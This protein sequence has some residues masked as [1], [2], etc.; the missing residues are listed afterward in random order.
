[1]PSFVPM[2]SQLSREVLRWQAARTQAAKDAIFAKI[3]PIAFARGVKIYKT[4]APKDIAADYDTAA[5]EIN[6]CIFKLAR[7]YKPKRDFE[8]ALW[9]KI[10]NHIID[11]QRTARRKKRR[12]AIADVSI[13]SVMGKLI[14]EPNPAQHLE[15]QDRFNEWKRATRGLSNVQ[16]HTLRRRFMFNDAYKKIAESLNRFFPRD[17]AWNHKHVE[18]ALLGAMKKMRRGG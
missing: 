17:R 4:V 13:E 2:R 7:V 15:E 9:V 10:C 6:L 8:T 16:R 18:G 5:S 11:L 12:G 3:Y 1:M 14:V